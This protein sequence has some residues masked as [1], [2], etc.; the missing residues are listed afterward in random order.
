M[1]SIQTIRRKNPSIAGHRTAV[2]VL[3]LT[4]MIAL[5]LAL[6]SARAADSGARRHAQGGYDASNATHGWR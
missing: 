6:G 1:K 5:G 4:A 3:A 2:S